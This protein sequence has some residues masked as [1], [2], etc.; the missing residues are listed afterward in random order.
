MAQKTI[1]EEIV[2]IEAELTAL[3]EKITKQEALKELEEGGAGARFR[4][5]FT[6][7]QTLYQR[8]LQLETRLNTLYR[9]RT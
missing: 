2:R 3:R 9:A 1:D 7:I 6:S 4:T 5:E 8:E